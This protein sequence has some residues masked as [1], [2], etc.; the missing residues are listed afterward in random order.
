MK[1]QETLRNQI[2][3]WM[4]NHP[5]VLKIEEWGDSPGSWRKT[6]LVGLL[7]EWMS[8]CLMPTQEISDFS[9]DPTAPGVLSR[10]LGRFIDRYPGPFSMGLPMNDL[11]AFKSRAKGLA[12]MLDKLVQMYP[13]LSDY[14]QSIW[15]KSEGQPVKTS[16]EANETAF[17]AYLEA[18]PELLEVKAQD[19]ER[20]RA[21]MRMEN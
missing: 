11:E 2:S 21:L 5:E 10:S 1:I 20:I 13:E 14:T 12:L 7:M 16:A 4:V 6:V 3:T 18:R 17:L 8:E 9:A 15:G 19:D